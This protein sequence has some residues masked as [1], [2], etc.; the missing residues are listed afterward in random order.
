MSLAST[1]F[2]SNYHPKFGVFGFPYL[3]ET[4]EAAYRVFDEVMAQ[5]MNEWAEDAGFVSLGYEEI[6]W[7]VTINN[8]R[9]VHKPADFKGIKIRVQPIKVHL[10]AMKAIG[11]NPVPMDWKD[12][13]TALQQG[14]IDGMEGNA[15]ALLA[16]RFQ[17]V[18]KY[19]SET[20]FFF[21]VL[22]RWINR[23]FWYSLPEDIRKVVRETSL[24][25][26][27]WQR[28]VNDQQNREAIGKM[29]DAGMK[30]NKIS[31]DQQEAFR[32]IFVS[33]YQ[34]HESEYGKDLIQKIR[35]AGRA[36]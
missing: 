14:V 33:V 23:D 1:A 21:E 26:V 30:L 28:S 29:G 9:P 15:A 34:Q 32:T 22:G 27:A 4:R 25:A 20:N 36:K 5:Q 16:T 18:T 12:L 10:T 19:L 35:E 8:V 13:Y 31:A 7:R 3:F 24:E 11:A 17:E 6:G 2:M